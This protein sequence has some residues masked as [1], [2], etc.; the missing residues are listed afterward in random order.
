MTSFD[1]LKKNRSKSLDQLNQQLEKISSKGGY[2]DADEGKFWK[3]NR[4]EAGNGMAII[5]FLPAPEGE[6]MPFVRLWDHGFQGPGGWYIENSL[7]TLNK[8]DPVGKLNGTLWNANT[9]DK[10]PE[11]TQARNQKRRLHYYSNIYVVKDAAKPENE[12]KVFLFKYG[13]KIFDKIND[14]MNPSFEDETPINPFDFWEG[15]N[16]RLKIRQVDGYA[17]YDKSE[18]D[19]LAPL[20]KDDEELEKVWKQQHS[21]Q[22]IVDPKNFKSYEELEAKLHRVLGIVS[23]TSNRGSA[24]KTAEEDD[25]LDMSSLK[26]QPAKKQ[27]EAAPA[28]EDDDDQDMAFFKQLAE[29]N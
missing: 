21:L 6:D 5:R 20:N 17:N 3:L 9:D 4:D 19:D 27:K 29:K 28:E 11:R 1:S 22:E 23:D 7:T 2:K 15:A 8:E 14:L 24:P 12:G 18:F 10:G 25:Q 13:K 16:F 26:S